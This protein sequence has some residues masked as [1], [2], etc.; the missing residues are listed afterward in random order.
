MQTRE[1][2]LPRPSCVSVL[3]CSGN[4]RL[5]IGNAGQ[6]EH[7]KIEAISVCALESYALLHKHKNST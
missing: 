5:K 7:E 2:P 6:E 3:S 1:Q 4:K